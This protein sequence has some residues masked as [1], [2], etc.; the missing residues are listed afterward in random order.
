MRIIYI[1]IYVRIL[2][3]IYVY[4]YI[5]HIKICVLCFHF[6][7]QTLFDNYVLI[8]IEFFWHPPCLDTAIFAILKPWKHHSCEVGPHG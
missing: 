2:H 7:K 5:E 8:K 3:N 6:Q 1:Y 4:R